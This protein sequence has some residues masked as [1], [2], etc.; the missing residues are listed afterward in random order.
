MTGVKEH[1]CTG[2]WDPVEGATWV[3]R[4]RQMDGN[5]FGGYVDIGQ[6]E[7]G[8]LWKQGTGSGSSPRAQRKGGE[9]VSDCNVRVKRA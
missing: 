8:A 7:K 6:V 3:Q 2:G 1:Y 4:F 9:A 5:D